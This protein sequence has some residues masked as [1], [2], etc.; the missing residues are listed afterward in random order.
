[1]MR[2]GML[3]VASEAARA[4]RAEGGLGAAGPAPAEAQSS[5]GWAEAEAARLAA[6]RDCVA[7][8]V[9]RSFHESGAFGSVALTGAAAEA[10]ARRPEGEGGAGG[11]GSAA[12]PSGAG[13]DPKGVPSADLE[14]ILLEKKGYA[15]ERWLFKAQRY[16]RYSGLEARIA[17]ARRGGLHSG[18]VKVGGLLEG[19]TVDLRITVDAAGSGQGK[20]EVK[21]L[22][23]GGERFG[24]RILR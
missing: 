12:A 19:K 10:A 17:F 20:T 1:M 16:L 11:E 9:L 8:V 7:A 22:A 4:I 5:E 24:L 13:K 18:W 21:I 3:E 23:L 2:E 14:F 15:P 6:L